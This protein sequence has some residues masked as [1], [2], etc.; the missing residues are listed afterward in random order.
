MKYIYFQTDE[1][2]S[3]VL[4]EMVHPCT[5]SANKENILFSFQSVTRTIHLLVATI[6]FRIGI[7]CKWV[8]RAIHYGPVTNLEAY[9][10][11]TGRA[12]RDGAQ[13]VVYLL[14]HGILLAYVDSH[15]EQYVKTREC[16]R[17]ELLKHFYSTTWQ[18][19]VPHLCCDNC[20]AECECDLP[21]CGELTAFPVSQ[22]TETASPQKRNVHPEQRKAVE[23]HL[24]KVPIMLTQFLFFS[25]VNCENKP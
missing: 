4:V 12:G 23:S 5:P 13:S 10:Q 22:I 1:N 7:D 25:K 3:N 17:E 9:I 15:M 11:E 2:P 18:H 14:Y 6:A 16:R 19:E 8:H 24:V 20:A 21:D